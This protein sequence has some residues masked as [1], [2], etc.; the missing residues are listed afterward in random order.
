MPTLPIDQ[1]LSL[2]A[3]S[4]PMGH[5]ALRSARTGSVV[6][7]RGGTS[8]PDILYIDILIDLA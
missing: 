2:S 6:A 5:V 4:H 7:L 1:K 3:R 8:L